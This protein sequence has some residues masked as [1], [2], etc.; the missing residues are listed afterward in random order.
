MVI[1]KQL[2]T[3]MKKNDIV[4]LLNRVLVI[5]Q[6]ILII[7]TGMSHVAQPPNYILTHH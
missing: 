6:P 3:Y 7:D 5:F 1:Q 4:S 2:N